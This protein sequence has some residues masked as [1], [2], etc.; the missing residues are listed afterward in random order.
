M[1]SATLAIIKFNEETIS[2]I[3][4]EA[5]IDD[6]PNNVTQKVLIP[7]FTKVL[8]TIDGNDDQAAQ[9]ATVTLV[10]RVYGE[11]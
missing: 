2:I 9:F 11:E 1:G 7:S 5:H 4:T 6:M 3:K 10:G 8:I